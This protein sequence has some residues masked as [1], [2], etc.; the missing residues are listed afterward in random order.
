MSSHCIP[1]PP[2]A[3]P[4]RSITVGWDRGLS[5]Y[6]ASCFDPPA[7]GDLDD[8]EVF[9]VGASP[10]ELPTVGAL[11][12]ALAPHSVVIPEDVLAQLPL[13]EAAEGRGFATTPGRFMVAAV[14]LPHVPADQAARIRA[15]L[16]ED[17][18]A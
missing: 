10:C 4:G 16:G 12:A 14:N 18:T 9:W 6:F 13:D 1:V 8:D 2:D 15:E 7:S 11:T 17:V 3:P 5:T